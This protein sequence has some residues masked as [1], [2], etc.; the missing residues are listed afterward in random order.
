[1]VL[2]GGPRPLLVPPCLRQWCGERSGTSGSTRG[3]HCK[4]CSICPSRPPPGFPMLSSS[5]AARL[6]SAPRPPAPRPLAG[7]HQICRERRQREEGWTRRR[8]S[9]ERCGEA[10]VEWTKNTYFL[11][12]L[13]ARVVVVV[14][15]MMRGGGR[16][17]TLRSGLAVE[18]VCGPDS[19]IGPCLVCTLVHVCTEVCVSEW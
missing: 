19:R 3:L 17:V 13:G 5:H 6:A 2:G 7:W 8:R 10:E 14:E 12:C 18:R 9:S 4:S 11:C 1:M 15:V 16:P